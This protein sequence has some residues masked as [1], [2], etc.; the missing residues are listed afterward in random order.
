MNFE[1]L[2]PGE[3]QQRL[4]GENPPF[5]LDVREAWEFEIC[6]IPGSQHIPMERVPA[7]LERLPRERDIVLICHHGLRSQQVGIYLQRM[8][9]SVLNLT[10]GVAAWAE[11][12]DPGMPRY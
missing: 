9:F 12:I 1:Q 6:H 10:G 7:S 2:S 11:Q 8:G 4:A 5:L 3:L